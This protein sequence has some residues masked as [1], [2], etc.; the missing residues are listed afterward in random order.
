MYNY[1]VPSIKCITLYLAGQLAIT[2]QPRVFSLNKAEG[3]TFKLQGNAYR[4]LFSKA[5]DSLWLYP[6]TAAGTSLKFRNVKLF[7]FF[8]F[9]KAKCEK[10][11]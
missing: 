3:H 5:P 9:Q 8:F 7:S 10:K 1:H 6:V 11:K 4:V 2:I